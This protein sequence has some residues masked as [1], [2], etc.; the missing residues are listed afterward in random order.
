MQ[1]CNYYTE[2]AEKCIKKEVQERDD[3]DEIVLRIVREI[4]QGKLILRI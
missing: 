2:D 1:F 4:E 3:Q